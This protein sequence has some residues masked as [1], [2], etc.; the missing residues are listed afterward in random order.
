VLLPAAERIYAE[1][2]RLVETYPVCGVN[3]H[4][5][6]LVAAMKV[7]GIREILS[8]RGPKGLWISSRTLLCSGNVIIVNS[9]NFARYASSPSR[10]FHCGHHAARNV[11]PRFRTDPC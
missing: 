11:L 3:A 7:H 9:V 10:R 5:R 1:W 4:D 8:I 2:L 6:R